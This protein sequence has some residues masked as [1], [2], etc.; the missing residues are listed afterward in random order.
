MPAEV[1][2]QIYFHLWEPE[3]DRVWKKLPILSRYNRLGACIWS[4]HS[5]QLR[6][7]KLLAEGFSNKFNHSHW[8]SNCTNT[9]HRFHFISQHYWEIST[10]EKS[11]PLKVLSET[12]PVTTEN[13]CSDISK[14]TNCTWG[15]ILAMVWLHYTFFTCVFPVTLCYLYYAICCLYCFYLTYNQ[16]RE[17]AVRLTKALIGRRRAVFTSSF[18][19][20]LRK[21]G[22]WYRKGAFRHGCHVNKRGCSMSCAASETPSSVS[23]VSCRFVSFSLFPCR[24]NLSSLHLLLCQHKG[25]ET[26]NAEVRQGPCL[27]MGASEEDVL[28]CWPGSCCQVEDGWAL[29]A[30]P[31]TLTEIWACLLRLI[32]IFVKLVNS[33]F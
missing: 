28:A 7:G 1:T 10:S 24:N 19:T 6:G 25:Q 17:T 31:T 21:I 22:V 2:G 9:I 5:S 32:F 26:A 14:V 16:Q 20:T 8:I 33:R 12:Y 4:V 15:F 29:P 3:I 30:L 11:G 27:L 13:K 18:C 23:W